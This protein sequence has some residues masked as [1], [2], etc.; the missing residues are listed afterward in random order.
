ML[1]KKKKLSGNQI[2]SFS[3]VEEQ[4]SGLAQLQTVYFEFNPIASDFEYKIQLRRII[5]SLEQIDAVFLP[6]RTTT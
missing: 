3:E 1:E 5:P 2:S 6:T 4:L